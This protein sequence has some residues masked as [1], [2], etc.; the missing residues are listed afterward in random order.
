MVTIE[1]DEYNGLLGKQKVQPVENNSGIKERIEQA[2]G[3]LFQNSEISNEGRSMFN[4]LAGAFKRAGLSIN[5]TGSGLNNL[6][7][8][9]SLKPPADPADQYTKFMST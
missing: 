3:H 4:V 6:K 2:F 8:E 7:V 9:I 5:I 1:L